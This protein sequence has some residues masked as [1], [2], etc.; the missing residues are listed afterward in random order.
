MVVV[1]EMVARAAMPA[2]VAD[3]MFKEKRLA[4]NMALL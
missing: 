4:A 3:A 1:L 2:R